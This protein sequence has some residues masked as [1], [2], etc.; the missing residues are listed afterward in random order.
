[1]DKKL[2]ALAV[3]E[4]QVLEGGANGNESFI[5]KSPEAR[6]HRVTQVRQGH[7]ARNLAT[8][9]R[10]RRDLAQWVG[11]DGA[12][13]VKHAEAFEICEYGRRPTREELRKLFPFF[14]EGAAK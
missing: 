8:A 13:K 5:P 4:S 6:K 3:M 10:F 14:E 12:K 11:E 2:D 7:A 1:M 9:E